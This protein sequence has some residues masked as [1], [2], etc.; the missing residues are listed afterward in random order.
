MKRM[1]ISVFI[2]FFLLPVLLPAQTLKLYQ[3]K[4]SW[5]DNVDKQ[6]D[7]ITFEKI[8]FDFEK[9]PLKQV[10]KVA[11]HD[12][13]IFIL[14]GKRDQI[15]VIDKNGKFLNTIGSHGQ[16]PAEIAAGKDFFISNDHRIYVLSS[17]P[18]EVE[19]FDL[20]GKLLDTVKIESNGFFELPQAIVL[21]ME[22]NI[23]LST[24]FKTIAAAHCPDG[25]FSK[26][27][28]NRNQM[29]GYKNTGP[30]LGIPSKLGLIDDA[31]LHFDRFK[32]FFTLLS[33]TGSVVSVFNARCDWMDKDVERIEKMFSTGNKAGSMGY[34][35]FTN[36]ADFCIDGNNM[37]YALPVS[38]KK[39][40]Y[41]KLFVF[42]LDGDFLYEK[43]LVFFKT[44]YLEHLCC[45]GNIFIFATDN[46]ELFKGTISKRMSKLRRAKK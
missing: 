24:A 35:T 29:A 41:Q 42:S 31:I 18:K 12:N 5:Q 30:K 28:L 17:S 34:S 3:E 7:F 26:A 36:W 39:G 19:V 21:D 33:S 11:L 8:N 13:K 38:R 46:L 10:M 2:L 14:D 37:I 16:G 43:S 1:F 6:I 9:A 45:Q 32:G 4:G 23:V 40:D 27:L 22:K 25:K 20:D 15:Y 44:K